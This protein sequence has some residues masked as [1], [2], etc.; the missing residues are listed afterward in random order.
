MDY[1]MKEIITKIV[2]VTYDDAQEN[3]KIFGCKDIGSFAL[4]REPNNPHDRNAIRV[5][6]G[7]KKLG[8][9]PRHL[10]KRLAPEIDAGKRF[11]AYFV[12]RNESPL[13]RIVGLTVKIVKAE[14]NDIP[15]QEKP[16]AGSIPPSYGLENP[17]GF[18]DRNEF[19]RK[20]GRTNV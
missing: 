15:Y 14:G 13:H 2:G 12:R 16:A 6:I 9:I 20:E 8:Y 5:D 19:N 11:L 10:A 17:A 7:G 4:L 3:I 1:I 18:S